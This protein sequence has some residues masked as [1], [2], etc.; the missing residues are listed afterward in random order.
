MAIPGVLVRFVRLDGDQ[1]VDD[2][3]LSPLSV[4]PNT[5]AKYTLTANDDESPSRATVYFLSDITPIISSPAAYEKDIS[6]SGTSVPISWVVCKFING[7]DA[8][9][10]KDAPPSAHPHLAPQ[11]PSIGSILVANGNT[12]RPDKEQDYHDWYDQEHGG[13]LTLVP[14]WNTSRRYALAKSY[15]DIET[16]SFYGFNYYD[17]ENGLGGAAWKAGVTEWTMRIRSNSAKPNI[18]RVWKILATESSQ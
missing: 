3:I 15:G 5:E 4:A 17:A 12:P 16:S 6:E 11:H 8:S 7:R 2:S 18:R 1:K 14:G 10:S 13:K 9:S